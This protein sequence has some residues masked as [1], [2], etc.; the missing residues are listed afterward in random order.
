MPFLPN[1]FDGILASHLIEH[2]DTPGAVKLLKDCHRVL[3]PEGVLLVSVPDASYFRSV[4]HEDKN[5]NW[6]RLFEVTDPNNTI[7]TFFEAALFFEQH[8]QVLTQDSLWYL[9]TRAGF[10]GKD[11]LVYSLS[12]LTK[13]W[14]AVSGRCGFDNQFPPAL[15]EMGKHLNRLPFSLIMAAIK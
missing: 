11:G 3:K 15:T 4:Y 14:L 10:A 8:L 7:P 12:Q 1:S 5:E 6:P 13:S 9:L 2:F